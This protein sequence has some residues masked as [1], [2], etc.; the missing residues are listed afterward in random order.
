MAE[1]IPDSLPEPTGPARDA[2]IEA[3]SDRSNLTKNQLLIWLAEKFQPDVPLHNIAVTFTIPT[4]IDRAHFQAAFQT[5]L[6]H[7]DALRTVIEEVDGLP[8]Q[9]VRPPMPYEMAYVDFSVT[10]DPTAAMRQWVGERARSLF[11]LEV[12]L[13]ES[14]LLKLSDQRFVWFLSHHHLIT[15]AWSVALLYRYQ[16]D[17]YGRACQGRL[18]E[19]FALPQFANFVAYERDQRRTSLYQKARAYWEHKLTEAPDPILFSGL[20]SARRGTRVV[21]VPC[22]LGVERSH[23]L[24]AVAA[25]EEF[26]AATIHV[27]LFNL[28]V[29]GLLAYLY[30]ISGR[31]HIALGTPFLNRPSRAFKETIGLFMQMSPLHFTIAEEETFA[32]LSRKVKAEMF[33]VLRHQR[34]TTANSPQHKVY[35]VVFNYNHSAGPDFHG[36][37]I[38]TES[39]YPGH[40]TNSLALQVHD[41]DIQ[42]SF[43]V[44]FDF[45]CDVFTEQDQRQTIRR[46]LRVLDA[47]CADPR[48]RLSGLELLT[49][50]ETRHLLLDLNRTET[51]RPPGETLVSLLDAQARATPE[52]VA[53]AHADNYLTYRQ[54][55]E[56]ADRLAHHLQAL[57]VGPDVVVGLCAERSPDMIIG[58]LGVLK[59]GGAYLPLDPTY[60]P[61]RLA[62]L[63]TDARASVL[64]TQHR[65]LASLPR[66]AARVVC[67]DADGPTWAAPR[68]DAPVS[69]AGDENLA[70]VIYTS[71]STGRP[72]GVQV[73]C[74]GLLHYTLAA[75]ELFGLG[76]E[77]RVLQ[78][79]SLSFDT[80]A[81][82]IFPALLRGAPL[83]LRTE[84]M[85]DSLP[86]FLQACERWHVTVLDLPTAYWHEL[87]S[88]L[89]AGTLALPPSLRL[90]I[91]GGERAL[92]ERVRDWWREA[93]KHVR[94]LNTYGPTEATVVA[95]SSELSALAEPKVEG[96][97]PIGTPIPNV[98]VYL[99]DPRSRL[100]PPGIP[101]ELHIGGAGLARGYLDQPGPTAQQFIP[102]P[103]SPEPGARLYRTGDRARWRPDDQLEFLG[104]VDEQVKVRGFRIEPGEI[105]AVLRDHP[106]VRDAVVVATED[107]LGQQRLAAYLVAAVTPA[108]VLGDLRGYLQTRL[109]DYMIPST[110]SLLD[111]L[112]LTPNGKVD[113]RAL[114]PPDTV[115]RR[116]FHAVGGAAHPGGRS[117]GA[118]LVRGARRRPGGRARQLLRAGRRLDPESPG[119]G[120][121]QSRGLA[122]DAAAV[123]RAPDD[124]RA[125]VG[126]EGGAGLPGGAGRA[127]RSRAADADP[128]LVL[129]AGG[130]GAAALQPGGDARGAPAARRRAS[131]ASDRASPHPSRRPAAALYARPAGLAADPRR[132]R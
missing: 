17:L 44:D 4:A 76:A 37:A 98:R 117:A 60:P 25:R 34:F 91:I 94:L 71:G 43:A 118:R 99:L 129:R 104:R 112:P 105:E 106:A 20:P 100:V 64:L 7:C 57:G 111:A 123:V 55:H 77:D 132:S 122:A 18:D 79:A 26:A 21:R 83:V 31:R 3:V 109:P 84:D 69:R 86:G 110:L 16:T 126:G 74:R 61:E 81:E 73:T 50:A 62:F 92:P 125:G 96:E 130:R 115:D 89:A 24:K 102:D 54:V 75:A 2:G 10:P 33:E 121:R 35:D 14:A 63:L 82:E 127:D 67:L 45:H 5:L 58:L 107:D 51:A 59:A 116:A 36:A 65:L 131:P 15:D 38:E 40:E 80:A 87:A 68:P 128:A 32:S 13:F 108:P 52:A 46:V 119:R 124:R 113:R 95:T 8:Q 120:P 19:P 30:C 114:P 66:H 9:R 12:R 6:D 93:P 88:A 47:V 85:L 49:A 72:K 28:F 39:I 41:Y 97:V 22:D 1:F 70:Y 78:F 23:R 90:V 29:T 53:V 56:R 27:S 11:Q 42:G 101:G 103:F 48:Q